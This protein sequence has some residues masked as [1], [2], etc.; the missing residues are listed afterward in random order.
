MINSFYRVLRAWKQVMWALN[1]NQ[2]ILLTGEEGCGKSQCIL[3]ISTLCGTPIQQCCLTPETEPS[4]LVGQ[5]IPN[6]KPNS[7]ERIVWRDGVVTGAFKKGQ[8]ILLD[9]LSQAESSVLERLNSV[10]C[11]LKMFFFFFLIFSSLYLYHLQLESPAEWV[12]TEKGDTTLLSATEGFQVL[13][14]MTPPETS[15]NSLSVELSPALYNRFSII[16]MVRR[17]LNY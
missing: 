7:S 13:G 10:V 2:P 15:T 9:N 17:T 14:T 3:A 6:D 8:W 4:I 11:D 12:L 5:L 16:H 1:T